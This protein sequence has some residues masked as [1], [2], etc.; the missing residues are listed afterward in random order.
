[1]SQKIIDPA[2]HIIEETVGDS[3]IAE[4]FPF[5]VLESYLRVADYQEKRIVGHTFFPLYQGKTF[6]PV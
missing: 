4:Y 5:L 6:L 3:K 1:L 2:A